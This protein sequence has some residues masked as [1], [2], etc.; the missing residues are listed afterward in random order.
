M[1]LRKPELNENDDPLEESEDDFNPTRFHLKPADDA[2]T[3][4]YDVICSSR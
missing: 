3:Q 2:P 4:I 1:L